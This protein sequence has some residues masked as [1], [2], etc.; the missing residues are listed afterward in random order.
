MSSILWIGGL[1]TCNTTIALTCWNFLIGNQSRNKLFLN[2]LWYRK[3]TSLKKYY[4]KCHKFQTCM[5]EKC[6]PTLDNEYQKEVEKTDQLGFGK[7]LGIINPA[8]MSEHLCFYETKTGQLS[9]NIFVKSGPIILGKQR[10]C[11]STYKTENWQISDQWIWHMKKPKFTNKSLMKIEMS[12]VWWRAWWFKHSLM[13]W[14]LMHANGSWRMAHG[15]MPMA[16]VRGGRASPL[17]IK[18]SSY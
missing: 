4:S 13:A 9:T 7:F 8:K 6:K 18:L 10:T 1:V 12:I 17:A 3:S 11:R 15:S 14:C 2:I 5:F 16:H